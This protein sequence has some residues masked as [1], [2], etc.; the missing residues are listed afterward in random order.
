MGLR[1]ILGSDESPRAWLPGEDPE[2]AA[3][4]VR[5]RRDAAQRRLARLD[6][7]R[8]QL[9]EEIAEED[10]ALTR[11]EAQAAQPPPLVSDHVTR[12]VALVREA[13]SISGD[14]A[15]VA[16]ACLVAA[17]AIERLAQVVKPL[18]LTDLDADLRRLR[19]RVERARIAVG[20]SAA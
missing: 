4:N 2:I 9:L 8:A 20:L 14:R 17:D 12:C 11:C 19:D 3:Q 10:A 18:A 7:E 6:R 1:K 15:T 13:E 5:W 16:G